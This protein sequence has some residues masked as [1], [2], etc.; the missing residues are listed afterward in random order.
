MPVVYRRQG[1]GQGP[2]P[3]LDV[4]DAEGENRQDVPLPRRDCMVEMVDA[5]ADPYQL[6]LLQLAQSGYDIHV[7]GPSSRRQDMPVDGVIQAASQDQG[8]ELDEYLRPQGL[9]ALDPLG[10]ASGEC[11]VG[12]EQLLRVIPGLVK[13]EGFPCGHPLGAD[14]AVV[15]AV[16]DVIVD[17]L[18]VLGIH[19]QD[20]VLV[21]GKR[22]I[23]EPAVDLEVELAAFFAQHP[24]QHPRHLLDAGLETAP[25]GRMVLRRIVDVEISGLPVLAVQLRLDRRAVDLVLPDRVRALVLEAALDSQHQ[26]RDQVPAALGHDQEIVFPPVK[27]LQ[28][29]PAEIPPVEDEADAPVPQGLGLLDHL[30][31]L[32]DVGYGP[33]I[34]LVEQ[35][36]ALAD[37][38]GHRNVH[39]RRPVGAVLRM[40]A[41]NQLDVARLGDLVGGVIGDVDAPAVVPR[42]VPP[43]GEGDHIVAPDAILEQGSDL[44]VA[45]Y[46][47]VGGEQ[48]MVVCIVGIVLGRILLGD[49]EV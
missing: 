21:I 37:V 25:L 36:H 20:L 22:E 35:R 32:G 49:Q 40:P 41:L 47:H 12:A 28:V 7:V 31:E 18:V 19:Q 38:G 48:R 24:V 11:L 30:L 45:V 6:D 42:V 29:R 3:I 44:G 10:A 5:V 2:A 34:V 43:F 26:R 17:L 16:P 39:N 8:D 27:V 13:Q 15:T 46:P 33:A 1:P 23:E 14:D 4:V 9:H